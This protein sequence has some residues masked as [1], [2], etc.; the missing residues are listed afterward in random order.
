[1][2]NNKS[3]S[4]KVT[5]YGPYS[6]I[7]TAGNL[8]FVSGQVRVDPISKKAPI[9]IKAQT[10]QVILNLKEVLATKNLSLDNIVKTTVYV[11]DMADFKDM[12]EVYANYFDNVKPARATVAVKELPK[13]G[14]DVDI[15]IEIDAVAYKGDQNE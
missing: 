10:E 5:T 13:V 6:P 1:M 2:N 4:N 7:K 3:Q 11:T 12:N 14:A 8:Y 15:V 9:G